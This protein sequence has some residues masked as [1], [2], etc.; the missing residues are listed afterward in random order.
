MHA[1]VGAIS[2]LVNLLAMGATLVKEEAANTLSTLAF[3]S[4]STQLAIATGIVAIV[5]T[6]P[7]DA[8]ACMHLHGIHV[9]MH[10]STGSDD[11][12]SACMRT[13]AH[14]HYV[15]TGS[16][17]VYACTHAYTRRSTSPTSFWS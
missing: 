13:R 3:N 8:Q 7:A 11:T 15:R 1:H 5:G 2:P 16:A 9:C 17:D 4:P 14:V 10:F 12:Q 6:G